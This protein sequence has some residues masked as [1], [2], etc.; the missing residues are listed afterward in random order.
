MKNR[1]E[2]FQKEIGNRNCGFDPFALYDFSR[3]TDTNLC[4]CGEKEFGSI[5]RKSAG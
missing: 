1:I 3:K 4:S 2:V 5:C